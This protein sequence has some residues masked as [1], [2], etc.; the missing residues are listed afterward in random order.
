M[1]ELVTGSPIVGRLNWC[2]ETKNT[3]L[4]YLLFI[5]NRDNGSKRIIP[6]LK[7]IKTIR[8]LSLGIRLIKQT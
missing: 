8:V 7:K 1:D 4:H 2:H 5:P 3:Y 6:N